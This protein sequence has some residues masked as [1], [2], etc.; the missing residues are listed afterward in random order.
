M[1]QKLNGFDKWVIDTAL[2]YW[3]KDVEK[4]IEEK[5]RKGENLIYAP[6]YFETV[7]KDLKRKVESMTLKKDLKYAKK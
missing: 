3:V 6:G 5:T 4:D 7:V 1:A 2:D